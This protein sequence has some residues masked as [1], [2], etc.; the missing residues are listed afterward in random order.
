MQNFW[1]LFPVFS[2]C[3]LSAFGVTPRDAPWLFLALHLEITLHGVHHIGWWGIN[4]AQM[5]TR[6]MLLVFFVLP[7]GQSFKRCQAH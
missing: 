1:Y 7:Q 5:P 4:P 3:F 6:K 2:L